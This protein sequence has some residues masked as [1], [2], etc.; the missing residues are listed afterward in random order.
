MIMKMAA[1]VLAVCVCVCVCVCVWFLLKNIIYNIDCNT[2][3]QSIVQVFYVAINKHQFNHAITMAAL[4][5][6]TAIID[7]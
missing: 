6:T 2:T 5:S 3:R 7:N 4:V 1:M